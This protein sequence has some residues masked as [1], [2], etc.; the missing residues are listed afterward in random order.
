MREAFAGLHRGVARQAGPSRAIQLPAPALMHAGHR[1]MRDR[2]LR[3]C[4][5]ARAAECGMGHAARWNRRRPGSPTGRT[6]DRRDASAS[7]PPPPV[8]SIGTRR[9]ASVAARPA[10]I[11]AAA[12]ARSAA[13]AREAAPPRPVRASARGRRRH[14]CWQAASR[15]R[16]ASREG[17]R[18]AAHSSH[19]LRPASGCSDRPR[20]YWDRSSPRSAA[21]HPAARGCCSDSRRVAAAP[22]CTRRGSRAS[23]RCRTSRADRRCRRGCC[24]A[25]RTDRRPGCSGSRNSS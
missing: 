14:D 23:R 1:G 21:S 4:A 7:T 2:K 18:S 13:A 3:R 24:R 20:R 9:A 19:S 22:R 25:D 5:L 15:G 12:T 17:Y 16:S 10:H 6:A 11:A 8:G